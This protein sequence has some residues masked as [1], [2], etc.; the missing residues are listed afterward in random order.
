MSRLE[1]ISKEF[2]EANLK[3]STFSKS[4]EYDQTNSRALS[5]GDDH[6]KGELN[7]SIGSKT[8]IDKRKGALAKNKYSSG[9]G[10]YNSSNA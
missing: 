4:K 2:R 10:E 1:E 7:K 8:D 9:T 5:D 3:F 6:G